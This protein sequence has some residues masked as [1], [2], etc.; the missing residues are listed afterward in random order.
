[1]TP[2]ASWR[3]ALGPV[4]GLV[5]V[6]ALAAWLGGGR[7]KVTVAPVRRAS[8][9]VTV[10]CAGSLEPPPGGELRAP[11]A[12]TVAEVLAADGATV[13]QGQALLRLRS[14]DLV[15]A[16]REARETL[17]RLDAEGVGSRAEVEQARREADYRR[18]RLAGDVRLAGQ[19]A[20]PRATVDE[21]RLARDEAEKTLQEAEARLRA[22][23]GGDDGGSRLELARE[24]ARALGARVEALTLRAP[25][26]GVAF[27]L[28]R[29]A[30]VAVVP[31][32][33]VANVSDPQ[34]PHVRARVDQ[35][36][37]PRLRPG[38]R[39]LMTFDGLPDVTFE[40]EVRTVGRGVREEDGREVGEIVGRI[41]DPDQRL[42]LNAS[43]NVEIVVGERSSV[44]VVPRAAVHPEG[45]GRYVLALHDGRAQRRAVEIGLVGSVEVEVLRG[46]AEGE[47]VIL[48]GERPLASGQAVT[49][50]P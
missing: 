48:P 7:T 9:R 13:A 31:G 33:V 43:V 22:F 37:L 38:Q 5:L 10:T 14:P 30:G 16:S 35:P 26:P 39:L 3:W 4:A 36:D 40:G 34:H 12:G 27:G 8:L 1:M 17:A 20:V 32:Q 41:E 25:F 47:Q 28:P 15:A 23:E 6:A 21:S 18:A 2:K 45:S 19:G 11:E 46:L 50:V 29:R 42:P 24:L 49:V 44:L